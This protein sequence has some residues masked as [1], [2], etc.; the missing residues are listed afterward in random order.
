MTDIVTVAVIGVIGTLLGTLLGTFGNKLIEKSKAS[1]EKKIYISKTQYDIEL[2]VYREISK[3]TFSLIVSLTT[4]YSEDHYR[5]QN[6]K[7]T[8]A[9]EAESYRKLVDRIVD[10]QDVLY[11]NAPFIP[12]HIFNQYNDLYQLAKEQ[13]WI[14]QKEVTEYL[15]SDNRPPIKSETRE[16]IS[17][18][19]LLYDT[20]NKD[21][22]KYLML[23]TVI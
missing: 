9:E 13:F 17:K 14:Y 16:R 5:E 3:K 11:E 10:V 23:L 19:E 7:K 2:N 4:I 12:E 6:E 18:I 21:L 15:S 1:N 8:R 22:R 20:V